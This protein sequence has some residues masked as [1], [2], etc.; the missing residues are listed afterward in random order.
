MQ[1]RQQ[2]GATRGG[3]RLHEEM[4]AYPRNRYTCDDI[5]AFNGRQEDA[6]GTEAH[7]A[8]ALMTKEPPRREMT[9][10]LSL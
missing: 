10:N 4:Y 3:R 6:V 1:G 5:A 7:K 8:V 2:G 9:R